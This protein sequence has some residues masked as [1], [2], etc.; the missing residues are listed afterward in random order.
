MSRRFPIRIGI[1]GRGPRD[2]FLFDRGLRR[3]VTTVT[4]WRRWLDVSAYRLDDKGRPAEQLW[5]TR[6]ESRGRSKD[7]RAVMP[8]LVEAMRGDFAADTHG[9]ASYEVRV[10]EGGPVEVI[11][12]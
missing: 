1:R 2:P 12:R 4:T 11:R 6:A 10:D 3:E 7:L 5:S 9:V 8:W